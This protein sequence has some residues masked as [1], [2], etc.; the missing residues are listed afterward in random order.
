[1][2][3]PEDERVA[4]RLGIGNI[5]LDLSTSVLTGQHKRKNK[6]KRTIT[7]FASSQEKLKEL[8]VRRGFKPF[9][10]LQFV[11]LLETRIS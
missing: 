7:D 1:M 2:L 6:S 9:M 8:K 11:T 10:S 4:V 5:K 3:Q